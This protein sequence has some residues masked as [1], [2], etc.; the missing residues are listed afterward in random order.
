MSLLSKHLRKIKEKGKI[1]NEH[2]IKI[3]TALDEFHQSLLDYLHSNIEAEIKTSYHGVNTIITISISGY[4]FLISEKLVERKKRLII[5]ISEDNTMRKIMIEIK[6]NERKRIWY[7]KKTSHKKY[8]YIM[9]EF[10][11]AMIEN[12]MVMLLL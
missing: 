6:Y 10:K 11:F 5:S 7:I 12:F 8:L 2:L 3:H 1:E 4:I 9:R